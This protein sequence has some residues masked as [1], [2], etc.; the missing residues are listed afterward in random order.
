MTFKARPTTYKGIKMRSRLEAG[1]AAWL[2][3]NSVIWKYE[4]RAYAGEDGQYLPDFELPEISFAGIA[5]RV[6]VEIKPSE[7][8]IATLLAQRRIIKASEPK[9]KLIAVWPDG[10]YYRSMLVLDEM[11]QMVIWAVRPDTVALE[12]ELAACNG[13][14]FGE[15]WKP[16]TPAVG[17]GGLVDISTPDP[18]HRRRE[19]IL[20]AMQLWKPSIA[21]QEQDD[22]A[23]VRSLRKR[24]FSDRELLTSGLASEGDGGPVDR[25]DDVIGFADYLKSQIGTVRD[26]QVIL[27]AILLMAG[28]PQSLLGP[29]RAEVSASFWGPHGL[30]FSAAEALEERGDPTDAVSVAAELNALGLLDRCGGAAYLRAIIDRPAVTLDE[31][32]TAIERTWRI[33][34]GRAG[35]RDLADIT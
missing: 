19:L 27:Y 17:A 31:L 9:A 21:D 13:P 2:D 1:F 24:G 4:P 20:T 5:S 15:Y 7:P 8:D 10:D 16:K 6:F 28:G 23:L 30:I 12:A 11:G 3:R 26:E 35:L 14:W 34:R 25:Y 32:T 22:E 29:N 33:T 18:V